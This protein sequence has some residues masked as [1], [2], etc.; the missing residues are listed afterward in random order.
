MRWLKAGVQALRKLRLENCKFKATQA[1]TAQGE[2]E[3]GAE[4]DVWRLGRLEEELL[5]LG[6]RRADERL[7]S[8]ENTADVS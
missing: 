3:E 5:S 7:L 1:P 4:K 2:G 6:M 8:T